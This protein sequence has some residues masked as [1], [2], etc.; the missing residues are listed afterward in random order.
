MFTGRD[1]L[2]AQDMPIE[3]PVRCQEQL[4]RTV[5]DRT[6]LTGKQNSNTG[7]PSGES[8]RRSRGEA[9]GKL[10]AENT[11]QW[12]RMHRSPETSQFPILAEI[13]TSRVAAVAAVFVAHGW[14]WRYASVHRPK[15]V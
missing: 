12:S 1:G 11:P 13:G 8:C 4:G 10:E 14:S 7:R 9:F 6:G 15:M 5:V 2:T 3:N